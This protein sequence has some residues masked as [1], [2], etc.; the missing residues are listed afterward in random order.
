MVDRAGGAA[1]LVGD[2]GRGQMRQVEVGPGVVGDLVARG[3]DLTDQVGVGVHLQADHRERRR[4]PVLLQQ[5][6]DLR[7]VLGAGP[8][9]DG[10]RDALASVVDVEYGLIR[11]TMAGL[12]RAG[13][14]QPG[15]G[16]CRVWRC[17]RVR[18]RGRRRTG[19]RG[20][21][22]YRMGLRGCIGVVGWVLPE[23]GQQRQ[24]PDD[25]NRPAGCLPRGHLHPQMISTLNRPFWALKMTT[26]P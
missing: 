8:V 11:V 5:L 4:H 15:A 23:S 21:R 19:R 2:R 14:G 7:G 9:V 6:E 20:V 1:D 22:G 12:V 24:S 18:G 17:R 3:L 26:A 13:P 25:Q 16:R 10:Q